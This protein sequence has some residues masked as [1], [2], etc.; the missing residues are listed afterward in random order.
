MF[1]DLKP[2]P[3]MKDSGVEWLG[4]V[5]AH[6]D[7]WRLRNIAEMRVSNVD[8][9][10]KDDERAVRLCNYAD[11]Y[12]NDRIR[13]GMPFMNAT[14][15]TDEIER[16]RL[17][18]GDVLITKDS[19][20]WNDIGVPALVESA[21]CNIV[22]GYHLALLRPYTERV[23]GGHLFRVL[24]SPA[25]ADQFY[26][27]A[28]GVTRYGLSQNAIKSVWLPLA[29]LAEQAAIVRILDYVDR[30]IRRYIR[31]KQKL[32][33]LLEEQKQ[34]V[35]H[36]AVTGRI[37]VLTGRPYPA[38]KNSGVEWLGDVPEHWDVRRVKKAAQVLRGKFTHRPRND[39]SLYDGPYPFI[40]T[41]EVARAQRVITS[42]RQT[43]NERG[44]AVSRMFP[45]GTLVMTIAANIG[46]VAVLD[47]KACFPD[48]VVGFVPRNGVARD[49]LYYVFRAMRPELL[50]EAPVNTQ[51]NLNIDRIGSRCVAIAPT[52]EQRQIVRHIES[53]TVELDAA[54]DR[55][56]R[57]V[58]LVREYRSRLIADVVTGKLDV[59]EAA[60]TLP[61][62]DPL[63]ADDDLDDTIDADNRPEF[64]H[65]E[66][67]SELEY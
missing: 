61:E 49:F 14:A 30:R 45:A 37:D 10:A 44:L 47:F 18:A 51:G 5:P 56:H 63:A 19:E 58:I 67:L 27:Q 20:T 25:V 34:A 39:P 46:D 43:L 7:V 15:T 52:R 4:E 29:P 9:H 66:E 62:V 57:E 22:S 38:Y 54:T 2:F 32:I 8:K 36:R 16:F 6:W 12:R 35:I 23:D 17:R 48:S 55:T 33:A 28:N 59:R 24:L 42:Y 3:A 26:V 21:G 50:R 31:A 13:A 64:D 65:E 41:G 53:C 40:Q 1:T 11:V 60:A